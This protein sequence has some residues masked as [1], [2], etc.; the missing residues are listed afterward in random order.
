[1]IG[2][3]DQDAERQLGRLAEAWE[4]VTGYWHDDQ[5]R[6]F[7]VDHWAPLVHESRQY[8]AA[9]SQL[10]DV[11]ETAERETGDGT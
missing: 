8:V 9:L 7:S 10:I 11:L 3:L 4:K 6:R 2:R 1:M 5:T